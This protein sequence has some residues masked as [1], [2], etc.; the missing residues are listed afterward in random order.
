[1]QGTC[2]HM[3]VCARSYLRTQGP[4]CTQGLLHTPV[5]RQGAMHMGDAAHLYVHHAEQP[6]A[7]VCTPAVLSHSTPQGLSCPKWVEL[8]GA[9]VYM[10]LGF[11]NAHMQEGGR[12]THVLGMH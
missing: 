8:A 5:H 12:A 11:N 6:P 2:M 7:H 10:G 9:G 3:P 1:M 4:T